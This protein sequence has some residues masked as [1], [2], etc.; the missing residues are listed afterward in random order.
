MIPSALRSSFCAYQVR[1][2]SAVAERAPVLN[3]VDHDAIEDNW[4]MAKSYESI[5]GPSTFN[6]F[7]SFMPGG[8][9]HNANFS[10]LHDTLRQEYGPIYKLKGA[11]GKR[12]MVC[13]SDP[14]DFAT[15]YRTEGKFPL[16]RSFE[17]VMHYR[18][19][20]NKHKFPVTMG[21]LSEQ[22]EGWSDFRSKVNSVMMKPQVSKGYVS[23]TDE[24]S[25]DFVR[26]LHKMRD[27]NQETPA[28]L[29]YH[30]NT[31][32]FEGITYVSVNMRLNLFSGK[33]HVNTDKLM[34]LLKEFFVLI[35]ELDFQPSLWKIYKTPKFCRMMEIIDYMHKFNGKLLEDGIAKIR[36]EKE[37]G[38]R[39]KEKCI[40]EKLYEIDKEI[41]MIM[42]LDSL[43]GGIDTTSTSAFWVIYNIARHPEKQNILREQ[44]CE[45]LPEKDTPLT[46]EIMSKLPYLKA[47]I[48]EALRVNSLTVGNV[49]TTGQNIVLKGYQ[50]PEKTDMFMHLAA[51]HMDDH[52]F[53][54]AKSFLP[55][56][57]LRSSAKHENFNPFTY[58]PFGFG[59]RNCVGQRVAELEIESLVAR[60]V[61]NYHVEWPGPPPVIK[62][63][64]FNMP[65][66][67]LKLRLRDV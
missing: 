43:M 14:K 54:D 12:D 38:N 3:S 7:R 15:I 53:P 36:V 57:W 49:R 56:R 5:P 37:K 55:E 21:L 50:I 1:C 52:Y 6:M 31:W 26:K 44:L 29:I 35:Y 40:F 47:T 16:R 66:G 45:F 48:K 25:S 17:S 22:G 20:E 19:V 60:L 24:V 11:F 33:S 13:V 41:A 58:L 30:L 32:A 63:L 67:D 61:R 18:M 2:F 59:S 8:R 4:N 23:Y 65:Q 27:S 39:T 28:D 34:G 10:F 46:P 42:T 51:V 9:F 62:S 64:P